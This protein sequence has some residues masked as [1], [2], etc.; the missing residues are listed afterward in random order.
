MLLKDPKVAEALALSM[1]NDVAAE[2]KLKDM[3]EAFIRK[4][5]LQFNSFEVVRFLIAE[6]RLK[7]VDGLV[8]GNLPGLNIPADTELEVPEK[9]NK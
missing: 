6:M 2:K 1:Q 3:I 9:Y 5:N 7:P 4:N 8:Y